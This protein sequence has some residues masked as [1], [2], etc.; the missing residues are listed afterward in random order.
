MT[1]YIF[2]DRITMLFHIKYLVYF[3]FQFERPI[4]PL[5]EIMVFRRVII[6]DDDFVL[7]INTVIHISL[8]LLLL[9]ICIKI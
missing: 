5:S 1:F 4:N 9:K 2:G 7:K 8:Q 3:F 6:L